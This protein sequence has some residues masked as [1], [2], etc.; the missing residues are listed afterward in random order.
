[1]IYLVVVLV[2]ALVLTNFVWLYVII[3][4]NQMWQDKDREQL[5]RLNVLANKPPMPWNRKQVRVGG[6]APNEEKPQTIREAYV[7]PEWEAVGRIDPGFIN[8]ARDKK[9]NN[10][11]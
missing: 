6:K 3:K 10:N 4:L 9:K 5:D 2:A 1:M 7:D 8:R 11:G